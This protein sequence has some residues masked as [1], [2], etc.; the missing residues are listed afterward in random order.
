MT[1]PKRTRLR[2]I[3]K[4][5]GAAVCLVL[6]FA[7]TASF[8]KGVVYYHG[9]G[10]VIVMSAQLWVMD[11][12]TRPITGWVTFPG[13]VP[14]RPLWVH[15]RF[16]FARPGAVAGGLFIPFWLPLALTAIPTALLFWRDRPRI[17]PGHC[18]KCGYNLTGNV[19]GICSECGTPCEPDVSAT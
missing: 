19:S 11:R 8:F 9:R 10:H 7:G 12:P 1:K 4:W 13:T 2:R 15:V 3:L 6:L 5:T 17:P 14:G 18:Q 16:L